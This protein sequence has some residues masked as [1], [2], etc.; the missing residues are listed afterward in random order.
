MEPGFFK[1]QPIHTTGRT[2]EEKS[3]YI[4]IDE[5]DEYVL[6]YMTFSLGGQ[7]IEGCNITPTDRH[8][9]DFKQYIKEDLEQV[10][11]DIQKLLLLKEKLLKQL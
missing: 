5:P 7:F 8:D 1:V 2:I 9:E 4:W 6:S 10:E 11:K 3:G